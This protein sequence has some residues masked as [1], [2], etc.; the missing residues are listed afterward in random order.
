MKEIQAENEKSPENKGEN[1]K[2][3]KGPHESMILVDVRYVV[4]EKQKDGMMHPFVVK[5]DH[6]RIIAA[7]LKGI[8]LDECE[9]KTKKEFKRIVELL[10]EYSVQP[11]SD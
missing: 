2:R 7:N 5:T 11:T 1:L 6:S 10:N 4:H 3:G 9:E 8:N